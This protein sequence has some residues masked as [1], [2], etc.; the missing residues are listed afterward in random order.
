MQRKPHKIGQK[1]GPNIHSCASRQSE[2][3]FPKCFTIIAQ[4]LLA[5][6][7]FFT[8]NDHRNRKTRSND[9]K[10]FIYLFSQQLMLAT[11]LIAA[12]RFATL[13]TLVTLVIHVL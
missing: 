4:K 3:C 13:G 10:E 7:R 11:F 8:K 5:T 2:Y 6:I 12:V 1:F 9:I